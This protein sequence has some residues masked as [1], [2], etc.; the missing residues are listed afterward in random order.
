MVVSVNSY[1]KRC[2]IDSPVDV[3]F[4]VFVEF[5]DMPLSFKIG[6]SGGSEFQSHIV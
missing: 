6:I 5:A 3:A 2:M 4:S 1:E